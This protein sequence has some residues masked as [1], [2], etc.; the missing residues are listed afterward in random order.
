M[1]FQNVMVAVAGVLAPLVRSAV[2]PLEYHDAR[3]DNPFN[4]LDV[5]NDDTLNN[6]LAARDDNHPPNF[7]E[8]A[9]LAKQNDAYRGFF[10]ESAYPNAAGL[11]GTLKD[12]G[13][14]VS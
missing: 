12:G 2:L 5:G 8:V 7:G 11:K 13:C 14:T 3:N 9:M 1:L 10:W 6:T 4:N